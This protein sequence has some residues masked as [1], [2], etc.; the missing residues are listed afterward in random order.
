MIAVSRTLC[1]V[2]AGAYLTGG[3]MPAR[4]LMRAPY[5]ARLL[6]DFS[7]IWV[8]SRSVS[9]SSM[10]SSSSF[11]APLE[12]PRPRLQR[13]TGVPLIAWVGPLG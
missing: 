3:K 12:L 9:F 13:V 5:A 2:S 7:A 4:P 6:M 8:S 11:A 10:V 1:A